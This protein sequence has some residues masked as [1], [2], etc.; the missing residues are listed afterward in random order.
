MSETTK[1]KIFYA[2]FSDG[3]GERVHATR[4]RRDRVAVCG[5][6]VVP[7][8][9]VMFGDVVTVVIRRCKRCIA[10]VEKQDR[11]I[12]SQTLVDRLRSLVSIYRDP[13]TAWN[14]PSHTAYKRA[15]S[16]LESLLATVTP[17]ELII[18]VRVDASD[19]P[20]LTDPM[21]LASDIIDT[22]NEDMTHRSGW[23]DGERVELL[24]A[25]WTR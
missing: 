12:D 13:D 4:D 6:D 10:H 15:A 8:S 24:A 3:N 25:E 20:V 5:A 9:G 17:G 1:D 18:R 2:A 19:D 11:M 21:D 16:D 22:F 23:Q 7:S 14:T